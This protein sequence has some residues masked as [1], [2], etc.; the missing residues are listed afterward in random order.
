MADILDEVLNDEKDEKRLLLFRKALPIIIVLTVFIAVSIAGYN[1]YQHKN[2]EHNRKIG[3]VFV[4]L[5]SGG[6]NDDSLTMESLEDLVK[7][8]ENRQ[9][10]LTELKIAGKLI[11]ANDYRGAMTR[12]ETIINNKDYYDITTSF[13]RLLWVNLVLDETNISDAMQMQARNYLQYFV[14]SDQPF[15]ASATLMKAL[16]YKKNA[17]KDLAAEYAKALLE[18]ENASLILK[19]QAQAI[20]SGI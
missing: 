7:N 13:A 2:M 15:F 12:L 5:I 4:E 16:F 18:L 3:D 6:Y 14:N 9:A 11:G 17:Q 19:E 20:L 8:S 10:E 1:W